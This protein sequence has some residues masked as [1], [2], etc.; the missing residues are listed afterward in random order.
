M[1]A[2]LFIRLFPYPYSVRICT[3]NHCSLLHTT[4]IKEA[5]FCR[6]WHDAS[7]GL[8]A[9]TP[10]SHE[11]RHPPYCFDARLEVLI[12][13]PCPYSTFSRRAQAASCGDNSWDKPRRQRLPRPN[14]YL[15]REPF[16]YSRMSSLPRRRSESQTETRL[17]GS[18]ISRH[19]FR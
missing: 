5:R 15:F 2:V 14:A 4:V 7:P 19:S 16:L 8:L 6:K 12:L 3:L 10:N 9:K 1:C 17:Q 11:R 13:H 18:V